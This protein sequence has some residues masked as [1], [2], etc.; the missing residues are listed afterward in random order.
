MKILQYN[1]LDTS[2][3]RRQYEKVIACLERDDFS[4]AQVKKFI[5]HDLYCARL[6]DSN[7]LIFKIAKYKGESYALILEVVLNHAYDKSK[8]LRGVKI[9][10][11][12]IP[13]IEDKTKIKDETL[14]ALIYVNPSDRHF[15]FLDKIISFDPEQQELYKVHPPL[16]IIGPA[17]SGKTALTLEKMKRFHGHGIYVTLSPYLSENARNLYYSNHYEN[18]EQEI[19]FLSFREFLETMRV[20]DGNE[21]RYNA[22]ANWLYRFPRQQRVADALNYTAKYR[23]SAYKDIIRQC[24]IYGIDHRTEFNCTPLAI[25]AMSGNIALVKELLSIGADKGA[26]DNNSMTAW[27]NVFQTAIAGNAKDEYMQ[28]LE[29]LEPS[30]ISLKV[31]DKLIKIDSRQGEFLIFNVFFVMIP[32]VASYQPENMSFT[33]VEISDMLKKLPESIIPDYRKKRQYISAML[34]KNETN[35]S[36]PYCRKLFKRI[37]RGHYVLNPAIQMRQKDG[38]QDIYSCAGVELMCRIISDS[39]DAFSDFIKRLE[40]TEVRENGK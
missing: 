2:K 31:D 37:R 39:E 22:F 9:D 8:F 20:P 40:K 18:D 12:K 13:L 24:E 28:I 7:R 10:E 11:S 33:A 35:S 15:H 4:S 25:A 3:V 6:D 32:F 34:A 38:W 17:G 16:I 23:S 21:I 19:S 36:S 29:I 5:E 1:D 14:P 26:T 30:D 27:Q